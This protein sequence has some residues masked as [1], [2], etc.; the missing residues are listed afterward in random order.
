MGG[1]LSHE[2][3]ENPKCT[4]E[5]TKQ[6]IRSSLEQLPEYEGYSI[7]LVSTKTPEDVP[8]T[9]DV[10]Y[11]YTQAGTSAV[12]RD[13]RRITLNSSGF[14]EQVGTARSGLSYMTPRVTKQAVYDYYRVLAKYNQG[15]NNETWQSFDPNGRNYDPP[16]PPWSDPIFQRNIGLYNEN[17]KRTLGPGG[18]FDKKDW[19]K[20]SES[21]FQTLFQKYVAPTPGAPTPPHLSD[22]QLELDQTFYGTLQAP[23]TSEIAGGNTKENQQAN[24]NANSTAHTK[25]LVTYE[26]MIAGV[27]DRNGPDY[28][29]PVEGD[30]YETLLM[31]FNKAY[32]I[33]ATVKSGSM[34]LASA[35]ERRSPFYKRFV[36][37]GFA[38]P[39]PEPVLPLNT[40][41]KGAVKY[42]Y[43]PYEFSEQERDLL[44]YCPVVKGEAEYKRLQTN[45]CLSLGFHDNTD[46]S[47]NTFES[48]GADAVCCVPM[49]PTPEYKTPQP[50]PPRPKQEEAPIPP[51]Y[52][53]LTPS[54]PASVLAGLGDMEI[55]YGP[56]SLTMPTPARR[57]PPPKKTGSA[58]AAPKEYTVRGKTYVVQSP[59]T[60]AQNAKKQL[61]YVMS[62]PT[63]ACT[64]PTSTKEGF[65]PADPGSYMKGTQQEANSARMASLRG[66]I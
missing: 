32:D 10:E 9:C 13:M 52:T 56:V 31:K 64:N 20:K 29:P 48:C 53:A 26:S 40:P 63:A 5:Q 11:N 33:V 25:N 7:T 15:W 16:L 22:V 44:D 12:Q 21:E 14:V 35:S 3:F 34:D 46:A 23:S 36:G 24:A 39:I 55:S 1:L 60:R 17:L 58:C 41:P 28:D 38:F 50:G 4:D 8:N 19:D 27:I 54:P 66:M 45:F 37:R 2:R 57:A 65:V 51:G 42:N 43:R 49:A 62:R 59:S 6:M 30:S 18:V 47:G 61:E